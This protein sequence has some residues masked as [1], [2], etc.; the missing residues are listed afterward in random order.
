MKSITKD[1]SRHSDKG[2]RLY[3]YKIAADNNLETPVFPK[4]C[5]FLARR[6]SRLRA[7]AVNH[8]YVTS[9]A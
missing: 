7:V 1:M 8:W 5:A 6:Q 9:K 3:L 4:R 2:I